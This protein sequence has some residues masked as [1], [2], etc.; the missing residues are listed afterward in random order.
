MPKRVRIA[1]GVHQL[2]ARSRPNQ[3]G[4]K[5]RRLIVAAILIAA[6]VVATW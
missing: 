4:V 6:M 2:H 3:L 5:P 1:R